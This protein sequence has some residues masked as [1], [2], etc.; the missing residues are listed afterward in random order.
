LDDSH[1]SVANHIRY[2]AL[3]IRAVSPRLHRLIV[4]FQLS[5]QYH[6]DLLNSIRASGAE[7]HMHENERL[8]SVPV[9]SKQVAR[10]PSDSRR[11]RSA[12]LDQDD[13]LTLPILAAE[14]KALDSSMPAVEISPGRFNRAATLR[15]SSS[16]LSLR[17]HS[18]EPS[19]KTAVVPDV[20][21]LGAPAPALSKAMK[22]LSR[23]CSI[24]GSSDHS[25]TA[26]EGG[27]LNGITILVPGDPGYYDGGYTVG[28]AR[29]LSD[30]CVSS[31]YAMRRSAGHMEAGEP[32]RQDDHDCRHRQAR[33]SQTDMQKSFERIP[34]ADTALSA[35]TTLTR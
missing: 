4:V 27:N 29:S 24:T 25:R 1:P 14:F 3:C 28:L 8:S 12:F 2:D 22:K 33:R 10:R 35:T 19:P 6:R 18:Q 34:S 21:S 32:E 13:N 11:R 23:E 15:A 9:R 26:D 30:P 5:Q 17:G 31:D 7:V 20:F 16:P